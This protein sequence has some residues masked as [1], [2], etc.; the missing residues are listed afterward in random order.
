M[1]VPVTVSPDRQD[2][3]AFRQQA[4][5]SGR[6]CGAAMRS[7]FRGGSDNN[8][9][10]WSLARGDGNSYSAGIVAGPEG[11]TTL[12]PC[13]ELVTMDAALFN[14]RG[15]RSDDVGSRNQFAR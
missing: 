13:D 3:F 5:Q 7:T 4:E 15:S 14:L 10:D 1:R 9:N 11:T 6:T 12:M 2:Y 8:D